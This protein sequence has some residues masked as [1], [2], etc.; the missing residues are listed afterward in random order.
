MLKFKA[1]IK[2]L[3]IALLYFVSIGIIW[4]NFENLSIWL[5]IVGIGYLCFLSFLCTVMIHNVVH[6][7]IFKSKSANKFFQIILS[8]TYGHPVSA[9]VV[10]HN[11]SHHQHNGTDQD[12]VRPDK[13]RFSWNLLNQLFFFFLTTF[14]VLKSEWFVIKKMWKLKRYRWILQF[15]LEFAAVGLITILPLFLNWKT[16]LLTIW[17]PH[18]WAQWAI[19]G[20]NYWQHDGCDLEHEYNHSRNFTSKLSNSFLFNNGYHG[21]HHNQP[22]LHWSLLPDVHEKEFKKHLHPNL[23]QGSLIKYLWSTFVWPGKRLDYLGNP[24]PINQPREDNYSWINSKRISENEK[25]LGAE[26]NYKEV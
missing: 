4:Y 13:A 24:V 10:A 9:F 23:D 6:T 8:M 20:V 2:T 14:G 22:N 5:R 25:D 18:F 7:P 11:L 12:I 19:M 16:T 15:L 1:D 26:S 21:L 3:F 17:L